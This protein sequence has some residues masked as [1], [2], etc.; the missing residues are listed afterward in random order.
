[1]AVQDTKHASVMGQTLTAFDFSLS[2]R[3]LLT[4]ISAKKLKSFLKTS[5]FPLGFSIFCP[6][7]IRK[8][9]F[10]AIL[11]VSNKIHLYVQTM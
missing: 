11:Q 6:E 10:C 5:F 7:R 2:E 8:V 9:L 3:Y 4:L 1:M